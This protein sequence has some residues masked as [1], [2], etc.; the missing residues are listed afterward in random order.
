MTVLLTYVV[1][2]IMALLCAAVGA[3]AFITQ[4]MGDSVLPCGRPAE[5][6]AVLSV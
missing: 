1:S 4:R 5:K 3:E 2:I 6:L